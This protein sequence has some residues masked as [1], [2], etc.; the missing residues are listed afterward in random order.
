M[1]VSFHRFAVQLRQLFQVPVDGT[2]VDFTAMGDPQP[3]GKIAAGGAGSSHGRQLGP[4]PF[5]A[6]FAVTPA[7]C[8]SPEG[9][10]AFNFPLH[11]KCLFILTHLSV[12]LALSR[13]TRQ[14][15]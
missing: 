8:S 4:V 12:L 9:A 13:V 1:L 11:I 5:E 15:S 7:S 2:A 3:E 10:D 6:A 14:S